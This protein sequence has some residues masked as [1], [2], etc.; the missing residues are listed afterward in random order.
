MN[1]NIYDIDNTKIICRIL[2]FF[3]RGKRMILFLKAIANPLRR[4]HKIFLK[5]AYL[6]IL[7][8]KMTS[9]TDILIW[10][11][12]YTFR[13]LFQDKNDSFEIIQDK[14]LEY[15]IIYNKEEMTELEILGSSRIFNVTEQNFIKE[16]SRPMMEY[17]D[18]LSPNI[19][20]IVA[21]LINTTEDY[22]DIKYKIDIKKTV[23]EYKASFINYKI[24]I[25][26]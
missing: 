15:L 21:P 14:E 23:D 7:K 22:T 24:V 3:A 8:A 6:M 5:W 16:F 2:P 12:N 26:N 13:Y 1:T 18:R 25:K 11:L 9:Q 4:L 17:D 10:Y 20:T 19:I